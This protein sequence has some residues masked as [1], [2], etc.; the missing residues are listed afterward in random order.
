MSRESAVIRN[1]LII[2]GSIDTFSVV[3]FQAKSSGERFMI[4][5]ARI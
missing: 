4:P 5:F 1:V 2:A 3:Y